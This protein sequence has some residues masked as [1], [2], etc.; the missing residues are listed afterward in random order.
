VESTKLADA[1]LAV[2]GVPFLVWGCAG[3]AL[4]TSP[5][6]VDDT[7]GFSSGSDAI[8]RGTAAVSVSGE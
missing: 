6:S 3:S 2:E 7:S 8:A 5:S 4:G 1:S